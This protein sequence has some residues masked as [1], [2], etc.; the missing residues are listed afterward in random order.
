MKVITRFAPSPTGFLHVGG[1]RTALFSYAFAK[2]N[3]GDFLLRIEDTD[4]ERSSKDAV[5]AILDG[6]QWLGLGHDGE[7][8]YQT[9]RL[10]L[11]KKYLKQL[12]ENGNAYYCYAS[13][14]ELE[15]MR[16]AQIKDGSKPR[17]DGRWRPEEGK[18]LPKIPKDIMPVIRFKNP[19]SGDVRWFD[20]V[21]GEINVSNEELDDFIIARSDGTPTYN[22]CVVIDD[23]DMA[24]SHV[25]RGDDHINNTPKQINLLNALKAPLPNYAHLSM[26]H[27]PDGQ[28]L[29]KR[30]G[31]VNV[32]QY[33]E[34]GYLPEA[35]NNY[36]SRLGWSHGDDEKFS[37]D[38]FCKWFDFEHVTSSSAQFDK[39]KL[40]W[41]NGE[42]I[43]SM[44]LKKLSEIIIEK[45]NEK[46]VIADNKDL[47]Y[48][49]VNLYQDREVNIN[50]FCDNI[51]YFI[52]KPD[53][54]KGL[55]SKFINTESKKNIKALIQ[56]L[57]KLNWEE[58]E[59]NECI[60]SYV[61]NNNLKFPEIAMPLR[62]KIAGNTNT[63][64]IGS[65]IFILGMDEVKRRVNDCL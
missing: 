25:I 42:Y 47:I 53:P 1:V 27:G 36:L 39:A 51:S 29:S 50:Q 56:E 34:E 30:H 14:E 9:K 35:L 37:M 18:T 33:Q 12:L 26:I 63:P 49:A 22:F 24:I 57:E 60:K 13:K 31:S 40:E 43:K 55:V 5:K 61:K 16:E 64:N 52:S 58:A 46:N 48:K 10:D 45:F 41:L 32:M 6:M 19:L 3:N 4:I 11:Y 62:V 54:D 8:K 23:W 7:I 21:K 28:K 38:D 15:K 59:I 20:L 65:I 44:D 17:Y 2:K